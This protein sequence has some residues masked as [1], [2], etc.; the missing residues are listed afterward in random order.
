[1]QTKLSRICDAVIEAGWLAALI[2]TPLFFNT[3]TNRVF[4]P[5]KLHL[6]RSIALVM[7]VAWAVQLLDVGLGGR[8]NGT[9]E[10]DA[11]RPGLWSQIRSTPLVLP[12]L[13]LVLA[14]VLSTLF[15]VAPR[16][17]LLGSYVRMQ[18]T[19]TFLSYVAIFAMVVTHLRSRA[20]VN[21]L[22]YTVILTSLPISIYAILQHYSLDPLPWGGDVK[23]RVAANMGNSIFVAAYLIMAFFLTLERLLDGMVD[24]MS[25]DSGT[26]ADSL[27]AGG[28]LFVL[29]VQMIAII[30][31]QSRGPGLGLAAGLYVFG[32]LGLLLLGR[33]AAGQPRAPR[34]LSKGVRPA[35]FV[36]IALTFA[37]LILVVVLNIPRGPLSSVCQ[38]RYVGRICTLFSLTEG[39]NAVR[40]LIWE[41]VVDMMLTPHDPIEYPADTVA[42]WWAGGQQPGK[43]TPDTLNIV[44][45]LIGYGPESMW[46]AY[47]RFYPPD[48]AHYEARNA[49][50]DRSHNETFDTLVRTGVLGF[51][52]QLYLFCSVFY[53]ALSWLG[54]MQGSRR[55][56]LFLGLLAGGAVLGVLVPWLADH[57]LRLAGIGLPIG[58][59]VGVIVYVTLE[60]LFTPATE[61]AGVDLP[62]ARRS[63]RRQLLILAIFSSIVA[64]FVEVHLGIAIASTL[65][66]FWTLAGLLVVVG[67]DWLDRSETENVSV[68]PA[69]AEAR[70]SGKPVP[71]GSSARH[72]AEVSSSSHSKRGERPPGKAQP[73]RPQAAARAASHPA[74]AFLPYLGIGAI[75][76]LVLTWD[77]LVNQT[78]A[79]G[80]LAFLWDSFTARIAPNGSQIIRS[81]MLLM[82]LVFTWAVGGL[83]ALTEAYRAQPVGARFRW[84]TNTALFAAVMVGVWL[85][86]GLFQASRAIYTGLTGLNVFARIAGHI[87]AFDA[88]LLLGILALAAAVWA[89]DPRP[90][91]ARLARTSALL[92]LAGGAIAAVIVLAII[93]NVN[94][95]TVQADTYYKQG[96]AY[97]NSGSW[98][99]ANI[100]YREATRLE[101]REDFYDL[102]LGR[103][104]L[105]FSALAPTGTVGLPADLNGIRT[106]DL[107]SLVDR[108]L[109]TQ[110][111]N[112]EDL[113]RASHAALVAALRFNPLNTDHSANLA[114]LARSW[115]FTN[116]LGPND[117]PSTGRLRQLVAT[118]PASV[119]MKQL[120][121]SLTFYRQATSLSPEN[122][123][124]WNE[125]ANV[126]FIMGDTQGA[127][128][129]LTHSTTVDPQF[130]QTFVQLGDLLDAAGNKAGAL[131]AYRKAATLAPRDAGVLSA[132]GVASVQNGDAEGALAAFQK[133]ADGESASLASTQAQLADLDALASRAGGYSQLLPGASNRRD[134]LQQG[135]AAHRSQLMLVNRNKALVLRDANRLPEAL[136]AAQ[137]AL[138]Y[139][140]DPDRATI[141]SLIAELE[142]RVGG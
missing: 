27:R 37:G 86:Y 35:W 34:W 82:L 20:Q 50:P 133:I 60:V 53:Y 59:I 139:A 92:P 104:L 78:G 91:P 118:Q 3:Y 106:A 75:I 128:D 29:A 126:Q 52:I 138:S 119:D 14:Y 135:I 99:G 44:R 112:R 65:T 61:P 46:V 68:S 127:L 83:L 81:P 95:Q 130:Y 74:S 131:D 84:G 11:R 73:A 134:A 110:N 2:V 124:L 21:R 115:A 62:G 51:S 5:D 25:G 63:G 69:P 47:N 93:V 85:V 70:V 76:T 36:L 23:E 88:V 105:Q 10:G 77:Y 136:Q 102:F 107:L 122:A 142:Q 15:S 19:L 16:I 33:W 31:T 100:L 24:L 6:L 67:M 32:M 96:L 101:P 55:R 48:L 129:T 120:N 38:K 108:G 41:G 22:L 98:E 30:F 66:L 56:N 141:E 42:P 121:D 111:P 1:M 132:L 103:A 113:I 137:T 79:Q 116:A 17:S 39:T 12:A 26:T 8:N 64:H 140:G 4:E 94:I 72:R 117:A 58:L 114:R 9:S 45:P 97:E 13:L 54:L 109:R 90:R 49:S 87:V 57:S 80:P 28:Y 7:L 89:A 123:Q 18:G 125:L 71:A 43:P 40:A